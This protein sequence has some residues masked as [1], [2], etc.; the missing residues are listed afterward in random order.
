MLEVKRTH[1]QVFIKK[2][3]GIH[4]L[5][6]VVSL[7]LWEAGCGILAV[8]S[9]QPPLCPPVLDQPSQTTED[10]I[11][12]SRYRGMVDVGECRTV[13]IIISNLNLQTE[14]HTG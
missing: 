1:L 13:R 2:S 12:L 10:V 5:Q 14:L 6:V 9:P 11:I 4:W 8:L 7:P 3:I